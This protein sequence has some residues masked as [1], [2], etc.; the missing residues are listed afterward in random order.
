MNPR[1][2]AGSRKN[3]VLQVLSFVLDAREGI[4][5][6]VFLTQKEQR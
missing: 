4:F 5:F 3:D 1:E 2:C 6:V